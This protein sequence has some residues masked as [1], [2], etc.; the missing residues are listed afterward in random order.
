MS[1]VVSIPQRSPVSSA[2]SSSSFLP[3]YLGGRFLVCPAHCRGLLVGAPGPV[4]LTSDVFFCGGVF[5]Q[6]YL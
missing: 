6:I 4:G 1:I 5:V 3:A 2:W